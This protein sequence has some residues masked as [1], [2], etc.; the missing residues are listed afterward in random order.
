MA[1]KI[2]ALLW[3]VIFHALTTNHWIFS[4]FLR[5]DPSMF[6][7]RCNRGLTEDIPHCFWECYKA[8]RIWRWIESLRHITA[9]NQDP[10]QL[11]MTQALIVEPIHEHAPKKWWGSLRAVTIWHIWISRNQEVIAEKRHHST[12]T[13]AKIWHQV[14]NDMRNEWARRMQHVK[15]RAMSKKNAQY[16]FEFDFGQNN[17]VYTFQGERIHMALIPPSLT[18]GVVRLSPSGLLVSH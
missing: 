14:K 11:T 2:N 3:Q 17:S 16:L 4:S 10:I 8:R 18:S 13:K 7:E 12:S 9:V 15:T 6:C 1:E 5:S